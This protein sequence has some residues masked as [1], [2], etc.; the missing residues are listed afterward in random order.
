MKSPTKRFIPTSPKNG[1]NVEAG[2]S[3]E[4]SESYDSTNDFAPMDFPLDAIP[5]EILEIATHLSE[6]LGVPIEMVVMSAIA[7]ISGMAGNSFEATNCRNGFNQSPNLYFLGNGVTAS[8]KSASVKILF[9]SALRIIRR[10]PQRQV[11]KEDVFDVCAVV[12]GKPVNAFVEDPNASFTQLNEEFI[13]EDGTSEAIRKEMARLKIPMFNLNTDARGL[14]S[15]MAGM[16]RKHDSSDIDFY[17]KAWSIERF[18]DMRITRGRSRVDNPCLSALW[19]IQ[20]D[21]FGNFFIKNRTS[22]SSGLSGRIIYFKGPQKLEH[23]P[24]S[25]PSLNQDVISDWEDIIARILDVRI[26]GAIKKIPASDSAKGVFRD[27]HNHM[28]DVQNR[29]IRYNDILGRSAEK[30]MRLALLYAIASNAEIIDENIASMACKLI[31]Y[32]NSYLLSQFREGSSMSNNDLMGKV[33]SIFE[34]H[35]TNSLLY[36]EF[37]RA[38]IEKE[39]IDKL[40]A[41]HPHIFKK[42]PAQKG[43]YFLE[44][45][46]SAN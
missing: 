6:I 23:E 12:D 35:S 32:S 42:I 15:I 1:D 45:T 46:P 31:E 41:Q 3:P 26:C 20:P 24:L 36:S 38:H 43:G 44:Y 13:F 8:G 34:K 40:V 11:R 28:V 19:L 27:F 25:R 33:I 4:G 9:D 39:D 18:D 29:L 22:V 30:A 16:Y 14:F 21:V 5:K 7:I 37:K 2:I 10:Q 17:C